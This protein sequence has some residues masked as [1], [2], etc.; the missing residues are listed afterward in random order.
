MVLR[1][2]RRSTPIAIFNPLRL[3]GTTESRASLVNI[4]EME[5]LGIGENGKTEIEVIKA[6][7]IIPKVIGVTKAIGRYTLP[8]HCP[9]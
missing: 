1:H 9:A 5:R 6:N 7:K 4:S 8:E 2:Y 3:E